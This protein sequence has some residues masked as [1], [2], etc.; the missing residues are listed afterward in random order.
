MGIIDLGKVLRFDEKRLVYV[1][2]KKMKDYYKIY[3]N[4]NL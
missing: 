4:I 2:G 3:Y 1:Q